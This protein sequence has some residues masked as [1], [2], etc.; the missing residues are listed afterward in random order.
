LLSLL[1]DSVRALP[2][3]AI[4]RARRAKPYLR[5]VVLRAEVDAWVRNVRGRRG[6]RTLS[7]EELRATRRSDTVFVFGS[8]YSINEVTPEEWAHFADHDTLSFNWFPRQRWVRIDYHLIREVATND[9]RPEIWR[10]ALREHAELLRGNPHYRDAIY[11][12]QRGPLAINGNR[13]IGLGLLPTGARVFRFTSRARH[14]V[15]PPSESFDQGLVHSATSIGTCVNFAYLVGWRS[16][17]L[18]GVDM[19]DHR[20]FWLSADEER[21]EIDLPG[22]G[23]TVDDPFPAAARMIETLGMWRQILADRGVSLSVY[24]P[25]SLL[26]AELPVYERP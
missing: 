9:L 23:L 4:G 25:R 15:E 22:R 17:V 12:V 20:Y 8:G 3:R 11:V 10:P 16:I 18:V 21:E 1:R 26:T 2:R 13:I 14:A 7:A 19:Y 6:Y 5:P 24:N